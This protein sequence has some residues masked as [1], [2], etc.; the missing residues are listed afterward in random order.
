M[1]T[2]SLKI[3]RNRIRDAYGE[4]IEDLYAKTEK[5]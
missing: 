2:P 1:L 5:Q 4:Q 3:K